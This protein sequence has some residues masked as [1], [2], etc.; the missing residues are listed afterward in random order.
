MYIKSNL[1]QN[2]CLI[3]LYIIFL[4]KQMYDYDIYF[5]SY[6]AP[7]FYKNLKKK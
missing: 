1:F 2:S 6:N 5:Q 7:N 3:I 4:Y